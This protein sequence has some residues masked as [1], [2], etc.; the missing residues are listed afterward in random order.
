MER[1]RWLCN[2]LAKQCIYYAKNACRTFRKIC[3]NY[4]IEP[5]RMADID[6]KYSEVEKKASM[7]LTVFRMTYFL[8]S[9]AIPATSRAIPRT[10]TSSPGHDSGARNIKIAPSTTMINAMARLL[11]GLIIILASPSSL[12]CCKEPLI[13]THKVPSLRAR[14]KRALPILLCSVVQ[15][16]TGDAYSEQ[17]VWK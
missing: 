7:R 6:G 15:T 14:S 5:G 17:P 12:V 10:S 16:M 4:S 9:S 13:K 3:G 2:Y 1:A 11:R 8:C